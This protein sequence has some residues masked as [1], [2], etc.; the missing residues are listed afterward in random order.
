[1]ASSIPSKYGVVKK[2]TP[3]VA[4]TQLSIYMRISQTVLEVVDGSPL[5]APIFYC[6][7]EQL[8]LLFAPNQL[9]LLISPINSVVHK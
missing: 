3:I 4:E 2:I 5:R 8:A 1:M 6:S 9:T 7:D